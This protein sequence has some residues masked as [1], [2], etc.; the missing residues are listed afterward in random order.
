M[1]SPSP[2]CDGLSPAEELPVPVP[3]REANGLLRE[4]EFILLACSSWRF[5]LS[6]R[7]SASVNL[8][9]EHSDMS[10][11]WLFPQRAFHLHGT[12]SSALRTNASLNDEI[13]IQVA[14]GLHLVCTACCSLQTVYHCLECTSLTFIIRTIWTKL[15][16]LMVKKS[17]WGMHKWDSEYHKTINSPCAPFAC[18]GIVPAPQET[19]DYQP[20]SQSS[21]NDVQG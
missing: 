13:I 10:S 1:W 4:V 15:L 8:G 6:S 14:N 3:S 18:N 7:K 16:M 12:I 9:K 21:G 11:I 2:S 20:Y 19:S 5:W 17:Y